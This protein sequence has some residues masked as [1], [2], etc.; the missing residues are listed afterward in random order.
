MASVNVVK[1]TSYD[2]AYIDPDEQTPDE[3]DW[4][5]LHGTNGTQYTYGSTTS[6]NT[7]HSLNGK[8]SL[9]A[10]PRLSPHYF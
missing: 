7:S 3:N 8:A 5:L 4:Q 9:T 6:G 10:I 1:R 2:F